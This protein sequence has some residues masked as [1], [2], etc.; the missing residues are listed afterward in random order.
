MTVGRFEE[1]RTFKKK[2]TS[3][4]KENRTLILGNVRVG[5][6]RALGKQGER[7]PCEKF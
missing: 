7:G 2:S 4:N 1:T 3:P 5:K 6:R